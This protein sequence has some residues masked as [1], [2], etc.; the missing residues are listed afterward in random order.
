MLFLDLLGICFHAVVVLGPSLDFLF[1]AI[2]GQTVQCTV[3]WNN[4]RTNAVVQV[5]RV[6]NVDM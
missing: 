5:S 2:L 6:L 1:K 4:S 3:P